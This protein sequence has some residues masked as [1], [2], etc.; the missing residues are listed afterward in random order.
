[1][2]AL[3]PVPPPPAAPP[4]RPCRRPRP[5]GPWSPC[6]AIRGRVP[7]APS[8]PAP[9]LLMLAPGIR[10]PGGQIAA[11]AAGRC[12][13]P[14]LRVGWS[15]TRRTGRHVRALARP[16]VSRFFRGR[17]RVFFYGEWVNIMSERSIFGQSRILCQSVGVRLNSEEQGRSGEELQNER[18]DI[19][20]LWA[21]ASLLVS[22]SGIKQASRRPRLLVW[23]PVE[24][25]KVGV[26]CHKL[27]LVLP[28]DTCLET[29]FTVVKPMQQQVRP[30]NA[31]VARNPSPV[32]IS[33]SA[34]VAHT[35]HITPPCSYPRRSCMLELSSPDYAN[36]DTKTTQVSKHA[37]V[38]DGSVP[39]V[40]LLSEQV[41]Y[42]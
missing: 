40:L 15:G 1:M 28:R 10:V 42:Q 14:Y 26:H 24:Y 2:L 22:Y 9:R 27:R 19:N 34:A 8:N 32:T 6:S 23:S 12:R 37:T 18:I 35:F 21:S 16:L 31:S 39:T 4:R 36:A 17:A 11:A 20:F 25:R 7:V 41:P 33:F 29:A 38:R 3:A 13:R 5:T 30:A